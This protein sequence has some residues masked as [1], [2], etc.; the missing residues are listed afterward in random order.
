M[1]ATA[2]IVAV[3]LKRQCVGFVVEFDAGHLA[4]LRRLHLGG[5]VGLGHGYH[6]TTII[7]HRRPR[8]SEFVETVLRRV[9]YSP[10]LTYN[11]IIQICLRVSSPQ[12]VSKLNIQLLNAP[13]ER[14]LLAVP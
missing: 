6:R 9:T 11:F 2:V 4:G 14:A 8:S 1:V 13:T 7:P 3:D 10:D 12:L 5:L